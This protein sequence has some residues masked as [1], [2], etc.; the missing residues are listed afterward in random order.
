M[1]TGAGLEVEGAWLGWDG[2]PYRWHARGRLVIAARKR[3]TPA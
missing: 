3:L 2:E 1:L